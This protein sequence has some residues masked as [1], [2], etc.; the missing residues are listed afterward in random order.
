TETTISSGTTTTLSTTVVFPPSD[1]SPRVNLPPNF[2]LP[3]GTIIVIDVR[4][5]V[6]YDNPKQVRMILLCFAAMTPAE[7]LF[8]KTKL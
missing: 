6:D 7:F 1:A 5:T 4:S 3:N 8:Y 2:H